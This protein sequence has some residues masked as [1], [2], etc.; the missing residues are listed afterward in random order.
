MKSSPLSAAIKSSTAPGQPLPSFLWSTS[1]GRFYHRLKSSSRWTAA[2]PP[3]AE[4][5]PNLCCT[6]AGRLYGRTFRTRTGRW[7]KKKTRV[8]VVAIKSCHNGGS[9]AKVHVLHVVGLFGRSWHVFA[10]DVE[11]LVRARVPIIVYEVKAHFML[12]EVYSPKEEQK[13]CH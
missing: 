10:Q 12:Q 9:P 4:I 3:S 5:W 8:T 2:W 7:Q 11:V 1:R 13:E 6:W